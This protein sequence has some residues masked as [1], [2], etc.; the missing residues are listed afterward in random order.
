LAGH[1]D[2]FVK[3]TCPRDCYDSCGITVRKE[4][5]R[6]RQVTGDPDH[7]VSGGSLCAKCTLAYNGAWI[8]PAQ[9]LRTPLRRIGPKGEGLFE[10]IPWDVALAEIATRLRAISEPKTILQTHYTGTCSAIAGNFPQR[11]FRRL[12]ATEVDPDTVCNKAGHVGLSYVTGNS[13]EGFDPRQLD[14]AACLLIWGANPSASAPHIHKTWAT[15]TRA[16]MIVIDPILHDTARAADIH[17]QNRPGSDAALAFGMLHIIAR[18][19]L[20][21][22]A[23]I[24]A[25]TV[26]WEAVAEQLPAMTPARTA[27]LTGVPIA[28][29]EDVAIAYAKGPSL[30]WLGQGM[31]RQRMG[32]NAFR[33]A[34]IMAGATG[35]IGKPGTGLLFLNGANTRGADL[36]TIVTGGMDYPD[37]EMV[38]QMDLARAL[39]DAT[40][41]RALFCW[42]NNIVA[43]NPEQAKLKTALRR[44]DLLHVVI[45]LFPT[46]TADYADYVLPAASFLEFDDVLFPYFHNVLSAQV[47]AIEPIGES[48]PNQEIFRRLA[49]AMGFDDAPLFETDSAIMERIIAETG[50]AEGFAGLAKRGTVDVFATPPVAYAG[51]VFPTPSG[52]FEFGS[53]QA[54]ADGHPFAPF[55]HAD[56]PETAGRLRLL[57]PAS[58]WTMN[59]SYGNDT[60][61]LRQLTGPEVL[62]NAEDARERGFAD[63]DHVDVVNELGAL[64][65]VVEISEDVPAGVALV[66]KGRWLKHDESRANVNLLNPGEKTDMGESSS[67]HGVS[68]TLRKREMLTP[69]S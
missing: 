37:P 23:F 12:G 13:A 46:D 25:H 52:K 2:E 45:D 9:R 47:K 8:D 61:V 40:R 59:S 26:G 50:F 57:S 15:R 43:S 22:A 20:L 44:E 56:E 68:V 42:N 69:L 63:G 67:V 3:T 16:K 33:S 30:L 31:Q 28:L 60:K 66:Y 39:S 1:D 38:S 11:F 35:N 5:G 21:D 36:A 55:P 62:L 49:A 17:L 51:G 24:A 29:I 27:A 58:R 6:I 18:E 34:A 7:F 53:S 4:A 14:N 19:G 41:S 32:G 64:P 10:P 48:L 65:A 54:V